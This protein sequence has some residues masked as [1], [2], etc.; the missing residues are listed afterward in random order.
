VRIHT[1][2]PPR[3]V[4]AG[5]RVSRIVQ[6]ILHWASLP[7]VSCRSLRPGEDAAVNGDFADLVRMQIC[8]TLVDEGDPWTKQKTGYAVRSA[9]GDPNFLRWVFLCPQQNRL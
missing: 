4:T 9:S 7:I 6:R 2:Q 1:L 3:R 8:Q 5:A